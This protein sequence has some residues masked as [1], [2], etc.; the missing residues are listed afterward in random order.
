MPTNKLRVFLVDD[1][2]ILCDGLRML[3]NVPNPIWKWSDRRKADATPSGKQK[4]ARWM[5]S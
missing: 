2:A 5:S 4:A 1:H 3:I